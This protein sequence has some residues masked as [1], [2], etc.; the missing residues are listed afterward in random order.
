M[1]LINAVYFKGIWRSEFDKKNTS[2]EYFYAE[3]GQ[4][5]NVKMMHQK[6]DFKYTHYEGCGYLE[7]PYGNNAFSMIVMLPDDNTA[8]GD[9]IKNLNGTKWNDI[10]NQIRT[11]NVNLKLP[12]F[13]LEAEYNLEVKVLPEIGIKKA[14]NREAD[15]SKINKDGGIFISQ[16]KHK[17]FVEVNEEGTEAAAVTSIGIEMTSP[18]QQV[19]IN[20]TVNKPFGF[21]IREKSTGVILFIGKI[22]EIT[23]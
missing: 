9:V 23:E 4:K 5:Q 18:G 7:M 11:A 12:R 22:G 3:G 1:Y 17:T 21:A 19:T 10:V 2:T 8:I 20:Y 13:K 16:V 15:F 6:E 14:F